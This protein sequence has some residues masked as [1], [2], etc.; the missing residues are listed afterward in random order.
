[1]KPT[2]AARSAGDGPRARA[3]A[4]VLERHLSPLFATSRLTPVVHAVLPLERAAE[5]HAL[6]AKNVGFGKIVLDCGATPR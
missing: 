1:L 5:A 6:V 2:R 4:R 3:G